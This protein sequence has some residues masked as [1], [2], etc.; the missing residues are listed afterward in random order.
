[1]QQ[2]ISAYIKKVKN[3]YKICMFNTKKK[4][5]TK[6]FVPILSPIQ[7]SVRKIVQNE[8]EIKAG[9][10]IKKKKIKNC[11]FFYTVKFVYF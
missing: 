2:K 7:W 4:K 6:C 10:F 3:I 11:I 1:M 5:K 9:F 8:I